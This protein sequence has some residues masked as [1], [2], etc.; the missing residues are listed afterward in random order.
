MGSGFRLSRKSSAMIGDR[1]AELNGK[2]QGRRYLRELLLVGAAMSCIAAP[3]ALA[4]SHGDESFTVTPPRDA[5][6]EQPS[7]V[8]APSST[9]GETVDLDRLLQLPS[10]MSFEKQTR[11]G[12]SSD[13]WRARFRE[14]RE[15]VSEAEA[16]LAGAR[17]KLDDMAGGSGGGG[18][19]QVA[20]PGANNT[21][22]TPMSFKLREQIREGKASLEDAEK[23]LR[24]LNIEADLAR[25]PV[26]WRAVE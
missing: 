2:G 9:G 26:E 18:Q 21:E 22:V 16:N 7:A 12:A 5:P 10:T 15:A 14:S 23:Q 1:M 4:D 6:V 8:E 13:E 19:W 11:H 3:W 17:A 24:A 25:V 20:P